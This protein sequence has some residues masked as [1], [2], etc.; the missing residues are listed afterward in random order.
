MAGEL[1]SLV[2]LVLSSC[3]LVGGHKCMLLHTTA[4]N[5]STVIIKSNN[6]KTCC[7]LIDIDLKVSMLLVGQMSTNVQIVVGIHIL[8][9]FW[10]PSWSHHFKFWYWNALFLF[11]N[12]RFSVWW[13]QILLRSSELL[14]FAFLTQTGAWTSCHVRLSCYS[15][16]IHLWVHSCHNVVYATV[17]SP[18]VT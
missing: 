9:L 17:S 14:P 10:N 6:N 15:L 16:T 1:S 8:F 13:L 5:G 7:S 2:L 3:M 4:A 18:L 12:N 11:W